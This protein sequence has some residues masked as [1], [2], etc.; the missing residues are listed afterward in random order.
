MT[1]KVFARIL[2]ALGLFVGVFAGVVAAQSYIQK[3]SAGDV[4]AG[5]GLPVIESPQDHFHKDRVALLLMGIDYSY[6]AKD[7]ETS[8][9]AR[10]DTIKAVAIDLP[11][12]A[13]PSGSVSML[14]VPRDTD[15]VL[16][17]GR[18]NKINAAYGGFGFNTAMAAHAQERVVAKFL[19]IP[20]FDR[21]LTLRINATKELV[22][23]IGGIDVIPD[24][25]MN[26]DDSWGH[27]HI[28]FI[29]GKKYHMNGEQAVSYA[30]FRHDACSDPCRI[31]RQDQ[32]IKITVAK[33]RN[34]RLNDLV[35]VNALIDVV[36]RNVYTDLSQREILS[37]AWAFQHIDLKR[38][39][40]EQ[41]PYV[42]D[43]D[44]ACCGNV[45]V[46]DDVR[47]ATFVKKMFLAPL[48]PVAPPSAQ[49]LAAV[50]PSQIHIAVQN[51][52]GLSGY[53]VKVAATLRKAGFVVDSIG[54]APTFAY[55]STEIHVV[56]GA[57]P[58][59]G[60]RVR[61]ALALPTATVAP[62]TSA[63]PDAGLA[64]ATLA[65]VVTVI[66]GRDIARSAAQTP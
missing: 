24:E 14:S 41:V 16:P 3:K 62:D 56:G 58:L 47:K 66:V 46:A 15:V 12:A 39:D 48:L 61:S 33:L 54:N 52:S 51:G 45:L 26:Y 50:K 55:E 57:T 1:A 27:L 19:G 4:M 17:S 32:V 44:L 49:A 59:V 37:L 64:G 7:Q 25:T 38:I 60:E 13:N 6:D 35:H 5:Y 53:G 65:N 21:Y 20:R 30:R 22:D 9:D 11:T 8:A 36:R 2:I 10:A 29:G 18:E 34:D 42:S 23:A 43:K 63:S 28:H 40:T 31:K